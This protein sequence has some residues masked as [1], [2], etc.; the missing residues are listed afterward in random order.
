MARIGRNKSTGRFTVSANGKGSPATIR[1]AKS[2][3]MLPLK[4]YGALKDEFEVRKGVNLS[5]P[6][7][8]QAAKLKPRKAVAAKGSQA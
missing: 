8:A 2:G 1:D 7:A 3:R 6:I 4:G 5:K